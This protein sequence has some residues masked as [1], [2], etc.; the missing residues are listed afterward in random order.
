MPKYA[1]SNFKPKR[2][3]EHRF[4]IITIILTCCIPPPPIPCTALQTINQFILF[5]A[6][7]NALPNRKTKME[8]KRIGFLPVKSLNLPYA[9]A[10]AEEASK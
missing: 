8:P 9:G 6:P 7:H 5:A 3:R 2:R 1:G 10:R 4:T